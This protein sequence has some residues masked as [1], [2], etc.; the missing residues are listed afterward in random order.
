MNYKRIIPCL[1]VYNGRVV[2][3]IKFVNLKD[4]GDPVQCAME[5]ERQGADELVLLDIAAT[6]EGRKNM[7]DVVKKTAANISV[8]LTVGG[9]ISS[10]ED[11]ENILNA[12][13]DKVSINTA[14]VKNPQLITE[15]AEKF[16]SNR[17]VLA[18]DVKKMA[19]SKYNIVI[20][21]G[22]EDSGLD[23]LQWVKKAVSGG[24]GEVLLT[25]MDADG[26]KNGYDLEITEL[27]SKSVNVPVIASG[28]VGSLEHIYDVFSRTKADGA[29]AASLFHFGDYTVREV[30]QYLLQKNIPVRL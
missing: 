18:A 23:A 15:A 12:G 26:T 19:D 8:P 3:G 28:G 4:A 11:I 22:K 2:K 24:A 17:I 10:C 1:D 9:G 7:V 13:A 14:A 30:K 27:I 20:C 25:S 5:Y 29:L 21:G 6:Q 16:G